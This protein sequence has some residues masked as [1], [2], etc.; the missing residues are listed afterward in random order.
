[1]TIDA[2]RS[3]QDI[4]VPSAPADRPQGSRGGR[5][6]PDPRH[7]LLHR[8]TP[9]D[10]RRGRTGDPQP[11]PAD[12][13]PLIMGFDQLRR[14]GLSLVYTETGYDLARPVAT[15]STSSSPNWAAP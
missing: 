13:P 6:G 5:L 14:Q 1:M 10:H 7:H 11:R 9:R 8:A 15:M 12:G 3:N 4:Q 2:R